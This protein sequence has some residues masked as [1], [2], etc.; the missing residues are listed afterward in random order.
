MYVWMDA[1]MHACMYVSMY[2]YIYIQSE[3]ERER[4]DMK[5]GPLQAT[6]LISLYIIID[7]SLPITITIPSFWV[8]SQ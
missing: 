8:G 5:L 3:R 7:L 1:C 2:I 4:V 6:C